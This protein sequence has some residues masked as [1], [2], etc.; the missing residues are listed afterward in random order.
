ML[1]LV[2]ASAVL[3]LDVVSKHVVRLLGGR[4][5]PL[6]PGLQVRRV[7]LVRPAFLRRRGRA[8][9]VVWWLI[10]MI[11]A[12]VLTVSDRAFHTAAAQLGVGAALGGGLGNLIE[13]LRRQAIT[14]FLDVGWWPVFNVAD[15]GIVVGLMFAL[16]PMV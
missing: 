16:W 8:G 12:V 13:V 5:Y 3:T 15:V 1:T 6:V 2:A 4:A 7:H 11:C 14:D 10:A 9:L